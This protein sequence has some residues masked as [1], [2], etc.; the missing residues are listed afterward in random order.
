MDTQAID[1]VTFD[2][3]GARVLWVIRGP[4]TNYSNISHE[5][6]TERSSEAVIL[7]MDAS[8][9]MILLK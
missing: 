4:G 3:K 2:F 7:A 9:W 6:K 5:S 8:D 1:I